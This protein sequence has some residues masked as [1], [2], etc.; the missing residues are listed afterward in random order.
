MGSQ[1][2][3]DLALRELKIHGQS[4][5]DSRRLAVAIGIVPETVLDPDKRMS[6]D[7]DKARS[8]SLWLKGTSKPNYESTLALLD[9]AGLLRLEASAA[10][11]AASRQ[12][13]AV[14]ID[15][16][17]GELESELAAARTIAQDI[18]RKRPKRDRG[19]SAR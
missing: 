1:E 12:G 13:A 2:V 17:I 19:A 18:P 5:D 10:L 14:A 16:L 9:R 8:A 15:D 7:D 3:F 6:K 11:R 4:R